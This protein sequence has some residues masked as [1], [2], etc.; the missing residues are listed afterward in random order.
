ML[1]SKIMKAIS[2][3]LPCFNE[4]KNLS[5]LT[6]LIIKKIPTKYKYEII[7]VDDGSSDNSVA[8]IRELCS[9]NK[10]IKGVLFHR[11]FGQQAALK[12]GVDN[13]RGD[14]VI[15]MDSDFQH[16]PEIIP[17]FIKR[18][19]EGFDLVLGRK[20]DDKTASIFHKLMRQIGYKLWDVLTNNIIPPYVSE[21]RLMD[22]SVA[23]Y[24]KSVDEK[25]PFLRG[26]VS[27]FAKKQAIVPYKVGSR[28]HGKSNYSTRTLVI[29]FL[30]GVISFSATPLRIGWIIGLV[31]SI[32]SGVY[33]FL[34]TAI[35]ILSNRPIVEGWE[36]IVSLN[37]M[38]GGFNILYLG[39]IAEYIGA[40][41]REIKNRPLYQ[42]HEKLNI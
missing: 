34:D 28:I 21:F 10:K 30:N 15:T 29:T 25:E 31:I 8:S 12:A 17:I 26:L 35:A 37:I 14:A 9:K 33:I 5:P 23:S 16:P 3:I 7:I 32:C 40:I 41:F 27:L 36:T 39:I 1:K 42:I 6:K 2:V 22:K 38:F 11:N 19:E 13:S 20:I 24:I 18:W 4:S